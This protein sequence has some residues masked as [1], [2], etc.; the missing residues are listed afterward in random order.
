MYNAPTMPIFRVGALHIPRA[1]EGRSVPGGPLA[2]GPLGDEAVQALLQRV[3]VGLLLGQDGGQLA[4]AFGVADGLEGLDPGGAPVDRV[5][6][7]RQVVAEALQRGRTHLADPVLEPAERLA[8]PARDTPGR[9][10]SV[11]GC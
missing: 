6:L 8:D 9:G 10:V 4:R 5:G 2:H 7:G 1:N 11:A 3:A